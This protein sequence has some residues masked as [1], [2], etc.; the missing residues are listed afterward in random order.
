MTSRMAAT[1]S[2]SGGVAAGHMDSLGV[3]LPCASAKRSRLLLEV[4][5]DCSLFVLEQSSDLVCFEFLGDWRLSHVNKWV[6]FILSTGFA[7]PALHR[8]HSLIPAIR[9]PNGTESGEA[10]LGRLLARRAIGGWSLTSDD[11]AP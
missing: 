1:L 5:D 2:P 10:G 9:P 6:Y 7:S 8:F 4:F 11:P 3:A